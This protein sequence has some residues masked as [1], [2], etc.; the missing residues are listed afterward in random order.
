MHSILSMGQCGVVK[1]AWPRNRRAEVQ[2]LLLNLPFDQ[3][4]TQMLQE[5]RT[6][7]FKNPK[8]GPETMTF[9]KESYGSAFRAHGLCFGSRGLRLTYIVESTVGR[10][11]IIN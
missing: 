8:S 4:K 3:T 2:T 1:E 9:L 6:P 7:N 5:P 11:A 10:V